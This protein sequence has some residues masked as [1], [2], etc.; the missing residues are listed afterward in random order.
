MVRWEGRPR[1]YKGFADRLDVLLGNGLGVTM[2]EVDL[3][4]LSLQG[5][6]TGEK[7]RR[8]KTMGILTTVLL[9]VEELRIYRL[10]FVLKRLE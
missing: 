10:W 4:Y 9:D 8:F 7:R 1:G 2:I 3:K 5:Q 6:G